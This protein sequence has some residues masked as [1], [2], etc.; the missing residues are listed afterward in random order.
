M[1]TIFACHTRSITICWLVRQN[2]E[3]VEQVATG[4]LLTVEKFW[5]KAGLALTPTY[6]HA[7]TLRP[8][9]IAEL[10]NRQK[11]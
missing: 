7:G 8:T 1:L 3:K 4:L 9:P 11:T 5:Q 2:V 6:R 10:K